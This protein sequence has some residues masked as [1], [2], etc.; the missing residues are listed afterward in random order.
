VIFS[1]RQIPGNE[2]AIGRIQNMLAKGVEILT[3]RQGM[4][5]VSGH[6]G[7]PELEA[8]YSWIRP[9]ILVP[10]HGE[11]RHMAEQARLGKARASGARSCR[12]T[13][14]WV[15]LAPRWAGQAG[16]SARRAA[17][18]GRRYHRAGRWRCASASGASWRKAAWW[19]RRW[20]FR[21]RASWAPEVE[22][23][24]L[25]PPLEEDMDAFVAEAQGDVEKALRTLKG[26]KARD[27]R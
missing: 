22:I 25:G 7:R 27:R 8:L 16:R 15:R 10:V 11:M 24:A 20:R 2:L 19:W 14:M 17:G 9:E 5:H 4:I 6:P 18:A 21:R 12:R 3:D 13:A 23:A 26:E 1:S